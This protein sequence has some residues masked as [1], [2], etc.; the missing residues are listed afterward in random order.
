MMTR[1]IILLFLIAPCLT[2][3]NVKSATITGKLAFAKEN[4][5]VT[6]ITNPYGIGSFNST[7]RAIRTKIH[8][9]RFSFKLSVN[10]GV[11]Y[12]LL[13][14]DSWS[15]N[16]STTGNDFC[17]PGDELV[18]DDLTKI[19]YVHFS[20][21][22]SFKLNI[23]SQILAFTNWDAQNNSPPQKPENVKSFFENQNVLVNDQLDYLESKKD[24]ISKRAYLLLKAKI[25]ANV[26][27]KY[28]YVGSYYSKIKGPAIDSTLVTL[29]PFNDSLINVQTLFVKENSE[30]LKYS[31][32]L[33]T[34][35]LTKYNYDSC[36]VK[37]KIF[38][39]KDCYKLFK[40][41]YKGGLRERIISTLIFSN[42]NHS[43]DYEDC[44]VDALKWIK[45]EELFTALDELYRNNL[46]GRSFF[47]FSLP[48]TS[49][50]H[51]T[52]QEFKGRV[53][54]LD[55]WYTGCGNCLRSAPYMA[56]IEKS[57]EGKNVE[58]ISV[59]ND[60]IKAVWIKSVRN[61]LYSTSACLNL[62]TEG[63]G[64]QH[65]MIAKMNINSFPTLIILDMKGRIMRTPSDPRND[66][67]KDLTNLITTALKE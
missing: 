29:R 7:E 38:S 11:L 24:L 50:R 60:K 13:R 46:I 15:I 63:L 16:Q 19:G 65:P 59:S 28:G 35:L 58:F 25:F 31:R 36:I 52:L 48:D 42:R 4:Q 41:R 27:A 23:N 43:K 21:K 34:S 26:L 9:H 18:I 6:L 44:I 12:F 10:Q 66:D 54:V 14:S 67:G 37:H 1:F 20:G 8:N 33:S 51:H 3:G 61:Q 64:S 62:N 5:I 55:F 57:F 2:F 32:E 22:G 45:N 49:G 40:Y 53:V 30:I 17:E 56:K 47:N 39:I